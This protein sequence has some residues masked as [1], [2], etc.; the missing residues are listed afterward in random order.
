[1]NDQFCRL[2]RKSEQYKLIYWILGPDEVEEV[3]INGIKYWLNEN[4]D[5]IVVENRSLYLNKTEDGNFE[6]DE[7]NQNS[8]TNSF[9]SI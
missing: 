8:R 7:W 9:Y 5:I 2:Q 4:D 6:T 1:M 3:E